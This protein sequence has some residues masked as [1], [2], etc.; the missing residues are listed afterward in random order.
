MNT[1]TTGLRGATHLVLQLRLWLWPCGCRVIY[2]GT[3]LYCLL[4]KLIHAQGLQHIFFSFN[5]VSPIPQTWETLPQNPQHGLG[6]HNT[7]AGCQ[8]HPVWGL[9]VAQ[10]SG[11]AQGGGEPLVLLH[12]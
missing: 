3:R 10:V 2:G 1:T 8:E 9:L 7:G 11:A 5:G 6:E 4:L 12:G